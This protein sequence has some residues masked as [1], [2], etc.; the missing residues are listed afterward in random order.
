MLRI[1]LKCAASGK[2]SLV[3]VDAASP[4]IEL[5]RGEIRELTGLSADRQCLRVVREGV[6]CDGEADGALLVCHVL[7]NGGNCILECSESNGKVTT[8][9]G[10]SEAVGDGHSGGPVGSTHSDTWSC[11]ACTLINAGTARACIVC[12]HPAP[13]QS[14]SQI[15]PLASLSSSSA[16]ASSSQFTTDHD[17]A[18]MGNLRGYIACR[19][20]I[21][22]DNSCLFNAVAYLCA[23][24]RG[25]ARE[26]SIRDGSPAKVLRELVAS[27]VLSKPDKYDAGILGKPPA[28]YVQW[29]LDLKRWGGSIELHVLAVHF[30]VEIVAIDIQTGL[31]HVH[32]EQHEGN[33]STQQ[34]CFVLY[35]G[36]HYDAIA[37]T[38]PEVAVL[39]GKAAIESEEADLTVVENT[40]ETNA[41]DM[42]LALARRLR[43]SGQFTDLKNC[44][45]QCLTCFQKFQGREKC[46]SHAQETGH[47]NYGEFRA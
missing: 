34:Q 18:G 4:F 20:A 35:S 10:R 24:K 28:E 33:R 40:G 38:T 26:P 29:I 25:S 22:S 11:L 5:Q 36:V 43:R 47:Q 23:G 31:A 17:I 9:G 39:K 7:R 6:V 37:F 42:A 12:G 27:I 45:V 8:E 15:S 32:G 2:T 19:R 41:T 14:S 1:K 30:N 16:A 21:P 3:R 46:V 13:A 44:N